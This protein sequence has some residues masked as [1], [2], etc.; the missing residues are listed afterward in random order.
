ML[1]DRNQ[2]IVTGCKNLHKQR[3]SPGH[4]YPPPSSPF[5][6]TPSMGIVAGS[7]DPNRPFLYLE[8]PTDRLDAQS[9][10]CKDK[11][12]SFNISKSFGSFLNSYRRTT[13]ILFWF[14]RT[15]FIFSF[16]LLIFSSVLSLSSW[17]NSVFIGGSTTR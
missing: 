15:K 8:D 5:A 14:R 12:F 13:S 2:N 17:G 9:V 4:S 7:T 3:L 10:G 16:R 1:I 6:P 11:S